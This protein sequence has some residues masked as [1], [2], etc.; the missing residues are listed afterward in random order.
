MAKLVANEPIK[1]AELDLGRVE[2]D[3]ETFTV[4]FAHDDGR[5]EVATFRIMIPG[6]V[7]GEPILDAVIDRLVHFLNITEG[8]EQAFYQWVLT[9]LQFRDASPQLDKRRNRRFNIKT[10]NTSEVLRELTE[11]TRSSNRSH[12]ERLLRFAGATTTSTRRLLHEATYTRP[13]LSIPLAEQHYLEFRH[14]ILT[15]ISEAAD[16]VNAIQQQVLQDLR[17][18]LQSDL[19]LSEADRAKKLSRLCSMENGETEALDRGWQQVMRLVVK[20]AVEMEHENAS[21]FTD[22]VETA[23]TLQ[24]PVLQQV[25]RKCLVMLDDDGEEFTPEYPDCI[26]QHFDVQA[27]NRFLDELIARSE[28]CFDLSRDALIT[29]PDACLLATEP[30]CPNDD[31][32][33]P[34]RPEI[35]IGQQSVEMEQY[36]GFLDARD[37]DDVYQKWC[38][39]GWVTTNL[40]NRSECI[41]LLH[42]EADD[43]YQG[44]LD[45]AFKLVYRKVRRSLTRL[46]RRV[47]QLLYFRQPIFGGRVAAMDPIVISFF[48]GMD[49]ETQLLIFLVLVL[50]R[51]ELGESENLDKK[52]ERRWRAYLRFYPYWLMLLQEEDRQKKRS[53]AIHGKTLSLDA[54]TLRDSSGRELSMKDTVAD[55]KNKP[56]DLLQAFVS[57]SQGMLGGWADKYCT[58]TQ[59][60]HLTRFADGST[61]TAIA[62]E[63]E[64]TQAAVSKSIKAALRRVRQGLIADG[65]IEPKAE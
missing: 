61:E 30:G 29:V 15:E 4:S 59:A 18:K 46:E 50:K 24:T 64:I 31:H 52:L 37:G 27:A 33:L 43:V 12:A 63:E 44:V 1:D 56:T 26:H 3:F 32:P 51:N 16:R 8:E 55:P 54:P 2:L 35:G 60:R 19:T 47:F 62:Q 25:R 45:Y 48:T 34:D 11:S 42:R 53:K 21:Q 6:S 7:N 5:Q 49:G 58:T 40:V 28:A 20:D 17:A 23:R 39:V 9:M 13:D 65:L 36:R 41:R 14:Q 22:L 38:I 57:A 10:F